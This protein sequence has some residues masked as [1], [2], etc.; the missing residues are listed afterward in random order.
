MIRLDK[1]RVKQ[2]LYVLALILCVV[3]LWWSFTHKEQPAGVFVPLPPAVT[4]AKVP[5]PTVPLK[6]VP[7]KKVKEK[8]PE[9]HEADREQD[10]V[11]DTGEVPETENGGTVIAKVDT[12]TGEVTTSFQKN[13]APW[14]AFQ[15]KNYLGARYGWSNKGNYLEPYYRRDILR[16]KNV[17]GYGEVGGKIQTGSTEGYVAVGVEYRW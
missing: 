10:E 13:E 6:V 7:K 1:E 16:V 11:V 14:F 12:E 8:F 5:G 3:Y 2:G 9:Y 4:V 17:Y 15:D